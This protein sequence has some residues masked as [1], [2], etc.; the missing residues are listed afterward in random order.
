M[1]FSS[2]SSPGV[3]LRWA[4]VRTMLTVRLAETIGSKVVMFP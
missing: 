1:R 3:W 2:R 4:T